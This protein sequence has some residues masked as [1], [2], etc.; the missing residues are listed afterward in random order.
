LKFICF[1]IKDFCFVSLN[2][3]HKLLTVIVISRNH[4]Y[5]VANRICSRS[6][7]VRQGWILIGFTRLCTFMEMEFFGCFFLTFPF[8]NRCF[9]V[10]FLFCWFFCFFS[11][12]FGLGR[13]F[14][15]NYTQSTKYRSIR[16]LLFPFFC[17]ICSYTGHQHD[18][19]V[20]FHQGQQISG[21]EHQCHQHTSLF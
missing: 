19:I 15:L 3:L 8:K 5:K 4:Y 21:I 17:V 13:T 10:F 18:V 7:F 12:F 1:D 14:Q 20:R 9:A 16:F 2:I 11:D 6:V